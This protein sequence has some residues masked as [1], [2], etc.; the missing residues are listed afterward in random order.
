MFVFFTIK[1]GLSERRKVVEEEGGCK[2]RRHTAFRD[3]FQESNPVQSKNTKH[4]HVEISHNADY[5]TSKS[6]KGGIKVPSFSGIAFIL[7]YLGQVSSEISPSII[8][9]VIGG[10]I[11][12]KNLHG[13]PP[14]SIL[15]PM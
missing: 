13:V 10:V 1:F 11:C 7:G 12:S 2:K 9:K 6:G 14:G 15:G 5:C 4:L 3:N 8:S